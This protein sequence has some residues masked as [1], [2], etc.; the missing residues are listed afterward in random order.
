MLWTP[1]PLAWRR[2][3]SAPLEH[4]MVFGW[5]KFRTNHNNLISQRVHRGWR[6][7]PYSTM[8]TVSCTWR[9]TKWILNPALVADLLAPLY[10]ALSWSS[11]DWK[12]HL[13]LMRL[14]AGGGV[15]VSHCEP[16][17][18]PFWVWW[19]AASGPAARSAAQSR[20]WN[21]SFWWSHYV[22]P[23]PVIVILLQLGTNYTEVAAKNPDCPP[24]IFPK[25]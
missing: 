12:I 5:R 8:I 16:R 9:C 1:L 7:F 15:G 21:H 4:W 23:D 10:R 24:E 18:T 14:S 6:R 25:P 20:H 11:N 2:F 22:R 19:C 17:S 3:C 13:I